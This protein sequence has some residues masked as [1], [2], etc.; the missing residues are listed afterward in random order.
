MKM[1]M[2]K[3]VAEAVKPPVVRKMPV[4]KLSPALSDV[5]E[6]S[7]ATRTEALKKIWDYIKAHKL[8][9]CVRVR[10]RVG[11]CMCV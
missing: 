4:C 6:V 3:D 5:L 11:E 1:K 8:Q 2:K 10:E 7:E 9:V